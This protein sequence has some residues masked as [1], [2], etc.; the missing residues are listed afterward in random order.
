MKIWVALKES[1]KTRK[2]I[3]ATYIDVFESRISAAAKEKRPTRA[4]GKLDAE[5]IFSWSYDME[6]HAKKCVERYCE[7]TN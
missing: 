7:L 3:V 5:T 6:G 2:D 4:S 1:V